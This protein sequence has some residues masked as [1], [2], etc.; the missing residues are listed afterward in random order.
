MEIHQNPAASDRKGFLYRPSG[1]LF[2]TFCGTI[3]NC[4][5]LA[6]PRNPSQS[7][8]I[9]APSLFG[10]LWGGFTPKSNGNHR[11]PGCQ[12]FG[13]F[14]PVLFCHFLLYL[15]STLGGRALWESGGRREWSR[16]GRAFPYGL[17]L[18]GTGLSARGLPLRPRPF[19]E[20]DSALGQ[21]AR[22]SRR[23]KLRF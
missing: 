22:K 12:C 14:R 18:F 9:R 11:N 15:D 4:K 2:V 21:P 7:S 6:D 17:L 13:D 10:D 3:R 19:R 5:K 1:Q 23:G 20:S 8:R 16:S